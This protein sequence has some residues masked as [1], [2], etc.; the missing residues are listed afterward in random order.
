MR[1]CALAVYNPAIAGSAPVCFAGG[2]VTVKQWLPIGLLG[3]ILALVSGCAHSPAEKIEGIPESLQVPATAVLKQQLRATGVQI[4][5]CM[6]D[7]G[8]PAHYAWILKAPEA[9]LFD[10]S[11]HSVGKHYAGPTWEAKDGSRV[12]GEVAA[13][14]NSPDPKSVAWLLLRANSVSAA[15]PGS[16]LFAGVRYVQRVHTQGGGAPPE[17]CS[18]FFVDRE[19]R[20]PYSAAYWFYTDKS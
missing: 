17:E 8:D 6:A 10:G 12:T 14:V 2:Y 20:V 19:V 3:P 7:K 1:A 4:Y 9:E 13:R 16:G 18:R 15:T 5:R 11:G